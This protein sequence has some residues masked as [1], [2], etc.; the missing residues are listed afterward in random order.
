MLLRHPQAH[1]VTVSLSSINDKRKQNSISMEKS[2]NDSLA[3][4][5][6]QSKLQV[7]MFPDLLSVGTIYVSKKPIHR[8]EQIF[9]NKALSWLFVQHL[10]LFSVFSF[11]SAERIKY[12]RFNSRFHPASYCMRRYWMPSAIWVEDIFPVL[13]RSAMVRAILRILV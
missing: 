13:S 5:T 11:F 10:P 4:L 12:C 7:K 8:D 2:L 6:I 9:H 3:I 1:K